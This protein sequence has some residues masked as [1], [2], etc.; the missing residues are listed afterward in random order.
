VRLTAR[1]RLL[2]A[3]GPAAL[4]VVATSPH[5]LGNQIGDA[6]EIV[7]DANPRSL[8]LAA[9]AML[10]ALVC[11][12]WAW[13]A[14]LQLCGARL[15]RGDA[16]ARYGAGSL[17]NFFAPAHLG[18]AVRVALFARALDGRDRVW[19]T[20]GVL[21]IVAA[22]RCLVLAILVTVAAAIGALP[23][24]PLALLIS[25]TAGAAVLAIATRG[26]TAHS[27]IAHALD[28]FR[29]AG[30][31][32]LGAVRIGG[33][34]LAAGAARLAG[35]AAIVSALGVGSPLRIALVLLPA[36]ALAAIVPLTPGN[37]GPKAGAIAVVL[38]GQGV[39]FQTALSAGIAFQAVETAVAVA[40]GVVSAIVL[41]RSRLV[42]AHR[43]EVAGAA[44]SACLGLLAG[45]G[46]ALLIDLV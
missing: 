29:A 14:A 20:G 35:A 25:A 42:S 34:V 39:G 8:W 13:R 21:A 11:S 17:V 38:Q 12:S 9:A 27:R 31:N 2:C 28:G 10:A 7:S 4:A 5:L 33:W 18:D 44:A 45:L 37:I 43:A 26:R 36:V 19:T 22:A 46:A 23:L 30:R 16:A 32:P 24:W 40:F 3:L 41:T 6:V 1:S 15:D